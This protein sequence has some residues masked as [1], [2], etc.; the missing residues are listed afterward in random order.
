MGKGKS[1]SKSKQKDQ[2]STAQGNGMLPQSK[3]RW[4]HWGNLALGAAA[5]TSTIFYVWRKIQTDQQAQDTNSIAESPISAGLGAAGA[6]ADQAQ[7]APL[8]VS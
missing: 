8:S 2:R 3:K 1:K 6:P 4:Q 5:A 7:A